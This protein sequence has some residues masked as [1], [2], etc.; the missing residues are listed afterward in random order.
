M[1][2]KDQIFSAN[3]QKILVI[4]ADKQTESKSSFQFYKKKKK[5]KCRWSIWTIYQSYNIP[6]YL[7][8]LINT[9]GNFSQ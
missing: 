7:Y 3:F 6:K 9:N 4:S 8:L 5:T 2:I 1:N